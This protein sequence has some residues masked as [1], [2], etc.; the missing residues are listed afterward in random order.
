M[1][2]VEKT[3]YYPGEVVNGEVVYE[4]EEEIKVRNIVIEMACS[5]RADIPATKT[6]ARGHSRPHTY[7]ISN[8]LFT[9]EIIVVG[10]G[11]IQ[12]GTHRFPF[13]FTIPEDAPPSYQTRFGRIIYAVRTH[14]D[15]PWRSD[16]GGSASFTVGIPS[17]Y[18]TKLPTPNT[19]FSPNAT[20]LIGDMALLSEMGGNPAMCSTDDKPSFRVDIFNNIVTA[21]QLLEGS[22]IV[23]NITPK[24]RAIELKLTSV[25]QAGGKGMGIKYVDLLQPKVVIPASDLVENTSIN[26]QIPVPAEAPPSYKGQIFSN[27]WTLKCT[28]DLA[29]A[30]DVSAETEIIVI[31]CI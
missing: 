10:E 26:F 16:I 23:A 28:L 27:R 24:L 15:I 7:R 31:N 21:G 12:S 9:Q 30:R 1:V 14:A 25:E 8:P 22:L 17:N 5:E 2:V 19:F 13:S 3:L 20:D 29:W 11:T 6:T 18:L 4:V